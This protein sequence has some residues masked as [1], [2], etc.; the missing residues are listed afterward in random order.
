MWQLRLE[1]LR[2]HSMPI[3]YIR[4]KCLYNYYTKS[5]VPLSP[6]ENVGLQLTVR[7]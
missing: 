3:A 7:R 1:L 5:D 6:E 4:V 2:I